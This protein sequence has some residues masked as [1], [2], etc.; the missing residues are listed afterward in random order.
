M[1]KCI[2][3]STSNT[4]SLLQQL[5]GHLHKIY[6][7]HGRYKVLSKKSPIFLFFGYPG[8]YI[9]C[10]VPAGW[11]LQQTHP[12]LRAATRHGVRDPLVRFLLRQGEPGTSHYIYIYCDVPGSPCLS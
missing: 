8:P 12:G 2:I 6:N 1:E 9:Y 11:G 7:Q 4:L 5:E 3:G 10:R